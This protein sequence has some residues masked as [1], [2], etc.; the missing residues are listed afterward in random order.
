[1]LVAVYKATGK[2]VKKMD[3]LTSYRDQKWNFDRVD[4]TTGHV[5]LTA[6]GGIEYDYHVRSFPQIELRETA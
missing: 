6:G 1:M 2:P 4:Q 5:V 3:I